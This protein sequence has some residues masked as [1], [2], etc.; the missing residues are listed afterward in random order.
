M[1]LVNARRAAFSGDALREWDRRDDYAL[2]IS[3]HARLQVPLGERA[4]CVLPGCAPSVCAGNL[5]RDRRSLWVYRHTSAF[6]AVNVEGVFVPRRSF[7]LA[8]LY[9]A[10]TC[11]ESRA[12]SR[13]EF[14]RWKLRSL[15]ELGFVEVD[16]IA[17]PPLPPQLVD[18]QQQ[19]DDL[20]LFFE[21]RDNFDEEI[22]PAPI[23]Q[24]FAA[25][26]WRGIGRESAVEILQAFEAAE[27]I[28]HVGE[29]VL[30]FNIPTKTYRPGPVTTSSEG[31]GDV[32]TLL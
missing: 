1:L 13:S 24:R 30:A 9:A 16:P 12:L 26:W 18:Y 4:P 14:P 25:R 32:E 19:Y 28:E 23:S 5:W 31:A 3:E 22:G 2:A 11:G 8:E 7:A 29:V 15:I 20:R 10:V 21:I 17:F 6:E 27:I